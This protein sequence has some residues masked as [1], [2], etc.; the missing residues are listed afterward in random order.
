MKHFKEALEYQIRVMKEIAFSP[1]AES[2][3]DILIE[4]ALETI[5]D[6]HLL[7]FGGEPHQNTKDTLVKMDIRLSTPE[8]ELLV[9]ME[10]ASRKR[11]IFFDLSAKSDIVTIRNI[12]TELDRLFGVYTSSV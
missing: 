4:T 12:V 3:K 7:K 8:T 6:L 9:L 11:E 5:R 2:K 1:E 10:N